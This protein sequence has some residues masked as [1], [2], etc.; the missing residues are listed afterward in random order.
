MQINPFSGLSEKVTTGTLTFDVTTTASG[1]IYADTRDR[2]GLTIPKPNP[3]SVLLG[4]VVNP[5]A[6]YNQSIWVGR[7]ITTGNEINR[8]FVFSP[9][10]IT[11][12][13]CTFRYFAFW[14]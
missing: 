14:E 7:V 3:N 11:N 2:S 10:S 1:N 12:V 13:S 5:E 9:N 8:L 4:A 6:P